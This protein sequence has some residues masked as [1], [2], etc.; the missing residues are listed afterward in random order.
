MTISAQAKGDSLSIQY[1][2]FRILACVRSNYGL[3]CTI[4]DVHGMS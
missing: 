4:G 1:E 3:A 2:S